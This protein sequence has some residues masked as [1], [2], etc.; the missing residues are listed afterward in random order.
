MNTELSQYIGPMR[1]NSLYTSV[2]KLCDLLVSIPLSYELYDLPLLGRE[3]LLP[4]M[5]GVFS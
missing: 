4:Y 1:F 2:Q 5:L 3:F